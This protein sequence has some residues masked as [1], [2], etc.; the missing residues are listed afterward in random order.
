M[1]LTERIQA[2]QAV[3]CWP[4][5]LVSFCGSRVITALHR[6]LAVMLPCAF[7]T[8]SRARDSTPGRLQLVARQLSG[9][10]GCLPAVYPVPDTWTGDPVNR[11]GG[12]APAG[13][14]GS[15]TGEKGFGHCVPVDAELS[16]DG[17]HCQAVLVEQRDPLHQ[18]WSQLH[19]AAIRSLLG[20]CGPVTVPERVRA[21]VIFPVQCRTWRWF[22]HVSQEVTEFAPAR[23]NRD[24]PATPVCVAR[25]FRVCAP[26]GHVCPAVPCVR[27]A[28]TRFVPVAG[29]S[30]DYPL[31]FQA[32]AAHVTSIAKLRADGGR[33]SSAPAELRVT[34]AQPHGAA[35]GRVAV[36]EYAQPAEFLARKIN[37]FSPHNKIIGGINRRPSRRKGVVGHGSHRAYPAE[38]C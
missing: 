18:I 1:G 12:P 28:C 23:V 21:I 11:A 5:A 32:S 37:P 20:R 35:A 33:L 16:A 4:G 15:W 14:L 31:A 13:F 2:S 9:G 3:P 29:R 22:A 25:V 26:L 8:A 34:Q 6:R 24:A 27:A 7:P 36:L 10:L 38:S 19:A 17:R 30:G